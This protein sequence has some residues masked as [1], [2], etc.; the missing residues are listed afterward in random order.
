MYTISVINDNTNIAYKAETMAESSTMVHTLIT[1]AVAKNKD[2][3][4]IL[5]NDT[6][7]LERWIVKEGNV[8][9]G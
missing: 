6:H 2:R 1:L 5:E 4:I 8:D 9:Y 7:V 3:E